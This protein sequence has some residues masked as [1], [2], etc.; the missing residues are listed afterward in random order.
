MRGE[1]SGKAYK[2]RIYPNTEQENLIQ[3]TFGCCRF[4]FN[5][6][7]AK[8]QSLYNTDKTKL[9]YK[10]CSNEMT[11]L[12]KE[13]EW[14]NEVDSYVSVCCTDVEI[15]PFSKTGTAIGLDLGLKDFAIDSNDEKYE[16]HK[17]YRREENK[18][19]K[20]QRDR[21]STRLNSSH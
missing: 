14:L 13:T 2:F 6:Y 4:V 12:K 18:L 21:K 11:I 9:S 3:K 16:N 20:L 15:E 19:K 8:K 17:F 7:H 1:H 5:Q 10:D